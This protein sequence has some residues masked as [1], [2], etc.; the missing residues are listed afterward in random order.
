MTALKPKQ[1]VIRIGLVAAVV[2][3]GFAL[4]LKLQPQELGNA[5]ASANGRIEA[6][7]VDPS[8]VWPQLLALVAIGSLFF[9]GALSR[10]RKSLH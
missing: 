6:T 4:W 9:V 2:A 10:L 8:I 7:E 1:M 5:F 3:A